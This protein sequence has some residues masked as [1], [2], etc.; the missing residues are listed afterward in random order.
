[1]A[2]AYYFMTTSLTPEEKRLRQAVGGGFGDCWRSL[3]P[4]R[5]QTEAG[6]LL[7]IPV[8]TL[9]LVKVPIHV[10][11]LMCLARVA[12]ALALRYFDGALR[13]C[14]WTGTP[15]SVLLHP[16][17]FLGGDDLPE[18][19]YFPGMSLTSA[20]KEELVSEVLRMLAAQFRVMPLHQQA[21]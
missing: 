8:T 6:T 4:Y 3:K 9:P 10:S 14:R 18:L 15:P 2:R 21:S 12:P 17:D 5:W 1:L 20:Q 19:A 11:Y 16:T 7:E 13:L